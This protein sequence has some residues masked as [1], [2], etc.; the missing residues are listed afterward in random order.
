[1][2]TEI[3]PNVD[4][5]STKNHQDIMAMRERKGN[6]KSKRAIQATLQIYS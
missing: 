3:N 2:E 5:F 6:K 1:M 4:H